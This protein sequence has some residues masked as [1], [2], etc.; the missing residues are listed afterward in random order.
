MSFFWGEVGNHQSSIGIPVSFLT[1]L[2][3]RVRL[4][5]T[6]TKFKCSALQNISLV[7]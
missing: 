2:C 4:L 3:V 7:S 5:V 1:R 6:G